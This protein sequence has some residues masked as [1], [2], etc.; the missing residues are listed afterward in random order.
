MWLF[1]RELVRRHYWFHLLAYPLFA[2]LRAVALQR[3]FRE[4]MQRYP[5]ANVPYA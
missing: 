1:I 5:V 2:I 4:G 3:G